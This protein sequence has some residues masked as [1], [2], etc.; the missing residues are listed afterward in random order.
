MAAMTE[1]NRARVLVTGA[2]GFI[3]RACLRALSQT[4]CEVVG[5]YW[6][7]EPPEEFPDVEWERVDLTSKSSISELLA[8]QKPDHLLAL[9]WTMGP[10]GQQSAENYRWLQHSID[11]IFAFAEHGGTR[12]T[13]C[14]SC[15]EYDWS[16][17][18][19][20]NESNTPLKPMSDYGAAKAA[21]FAAYG[22]LCEKLGL[23]G[24]WVRP[25]FVYGPN[26]DRRRLASDVI[27]SLL[28][29]RDALCTSG[30]QRRDYLHV[31]DLGQA[32]VALLFSTLEGPMNAAS[33]AAIALSELVQ[34]VSR[35]VGGKGRVVLGARETRP[36]DP[37]LVEADVTRLS[38]D[39]DWT[40]QY[41]L[42]SG[43]R[44]TIEWWRNELA[45]ENSTMKDADK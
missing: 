32:M 30:T 31:D 6:N 27:I 18:T 34:E 28:Q 44:Q 14:G 8:K 19:K 39:L 33:G 5:T 24:S 3:G 40:P 21:L 1:G 4:D 10:G 20:L 41:G 17:E 37:P 43:L 9:A 7:G 13:F 38:E 15:M 26:E 23:S 35:Q 2:S 25:F 45:R 42:E 22:P 29:D 11:L 16:Q 36:G 12:V